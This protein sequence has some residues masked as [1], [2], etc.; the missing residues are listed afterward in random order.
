M[1]S[2]ASRFFSHLA[3]KID[4]QDIDGIISFNPIEWLEGR[5]WPPEKKDKYYL[6]MRKEWANSTVAHGAY[7]TMVKAGEVY[8]SDVLPA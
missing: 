3:S 1:R 6:N 2:I 8:Y 4:S 7:K 5:N